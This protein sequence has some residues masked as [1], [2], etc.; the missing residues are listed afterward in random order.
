MITGVNTTQSGGVTYTVVGKPVGCAKVVVDKTTGGFSFL[1]YA[2][3][4]TTDSTGTFRILVAETS[5]I[6]AV[7]ERLPIVKTLVQP[8]II[9]LHELPVVRDVLAPVIGR[10]KIYTIEV[11]VGSFVGEDKAPIA[12][13][14]TVASSLDGTPISVNWFPRIGLGPSDEA[15]TILNGPSLATAGYIDPT[16]ELTVFGLVP[17][18]KP[19]RAAGYNVVTW[20][21][22]GE[23]ASGGVLHLDS[24]YY[25]AVD[26]ASI[27]D[28]VAEQKNTALDPGS[29]T[30]PLIGMV[31]GSYGGGIQL[32]TAGTDG[33]VDAIA[34]GIAWNN[35]VTTL[36]P[37]DAF[38]T[39]WSSLLL[40]SLVVSGSRIDS[41]I[42][43]GILT[44]ALAGFLTKGQQDFLNE[45]SPDNVVG[46]IKVPTLFLQGTV[47]TL[48]PLQQALKNAAALDP[49]VPVK[50]IWY[51]GGHGKC[52]DP[53]DQD[54]QSAFLVNET[55]AW[56]NTYVKG[57][58]VDAPPPVT[59]P[60]FEWIDQTGNLYSTN[61][62]PTDPSN[63]FGPS[64]SASGEGRIL[65]IVPV[66]GGSGPQNK[67]GFPVSLV[68][69]AP[70]KNAV[71]VSLPTVSEIT[72][73]VGAPELTLTYSG[74][75]TA[76]TVYAQIVDE[77]TKRVVGNIVSPIPVKLD[78]TRQSVT[79]K[80]ENIAYTMTTHG[81]ADAAD[82]HVCH[83]VRE[84]DGLRRDQ[85]RQG[86]LDVADREERDRTCPSACAS[87]QAADV[88]PRADAGGPPVGQ[89]AR[90]DVIDPTPRGRGAHRPFRPRAAPKAFPG[91]LVGQLWTAPPVFD[92]AMVRGEAVIHPP[93]HRLGTAADAE[94][95]VNRSDVGLHGVGAQVGKSRDVG[96]ALALSDQR[97]DLSLAIAESFAAA[98]PVQPGDAARS[99]GHIA[100]DGLP[101]VH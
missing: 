23:F 18:L 72:Y 71:N 76:R 78:G 13:T 88:P 87:G 63:F 100:D 25:E 28:W 17:G 65:P 58:T 32:T 49:S 6:D 45:N 9:R 75:G 89:V 97:Q 94:L 93:Q 35:L 33:R 39:S 1:P 85:H 22:R 10:S 86:R 37:H 101:G 59:G 77:S 16:Q 95:A 62:L 21:P 43:S 24:P 4:L 11:P 74:L 80:M 7:L 61:H 66:I 57:K 14:T 47:D 52:L 56:M 46:D 29:T 42:Y 26:V 20:D 70:A 81:S 48:F 68:L 40:L 83:T 79:V 92:A 44:G 84:R 54:R 96:V 27:I 82:R 91:W 69:G 34:P 53:V 41:E 8:I 3:Q 31:G 5:I 98:G 67:A 15:P 12:F 30:D 51:C 60:T 38:K 50:M 19:L 2:S 55:L 99:L 73:V 36:Y 90:D 64:I